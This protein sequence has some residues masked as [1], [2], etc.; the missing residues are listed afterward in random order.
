MASSGNRPRLLVVE[1]LC[2]GVVRGAPVGVLCEGLSMA[3]AVAEDFQRAGY[4][5]DLLI[6]DGVLGRLAWRPHTSYSLRVVSGI[7]LQELAAMSR[8]YDC[9]YVI[10]PESDGIL[11]GILR[12]LET[13]YV[14]SSPEAVEEAADKAE[15]RSRLAGR[16]VMVPE[17]ITVARGGVAEAV[18]WARDVGY[19]VVVKARVGVGCEGLRLV[20]C[21]EALEEALHAT[22][23]RHGEAV[24]QRFVKGVPASVS[25]VTGDATIPLTLNRQFISLSRGAYL[26]GYTPMRHRLARAALEAARR[27]VEAFRGLRGYVGVDLVLSEEGPFVVEVNPRLTVSYI[28]V[29]RVLKANPAELIVRPRERR[30]AK[31]GITAYFRKV[32]VPSWPAGIEAAAPPVIERGRLHAIGIV[33]GG[34]AREAAMRFRRSL[35]T[36]QRPRRS[37]M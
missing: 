25:L 5:V 13:A 27:A 29:R 1:A 10:A 20:S 36:Y 31:R 30:P 26:G 28:G 16:G 17:S 37:A 7:S 22:L 12:K 34:L 3:M 19:P 11:A 2:A 21:R 4:G 33:T 9:I 24:V 23:A 18:R 35:S 14:N 15:L 32:S 8:G 6:D